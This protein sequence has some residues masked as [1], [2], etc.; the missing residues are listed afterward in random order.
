MNCDEEKPACLNCCSTGRACDGDLPVE[1]GRATPQATTLDERSPGPSVPSIHAVSSSIPGTHEERRCFENFRRRFVV[2]FS[3]YF[4][5][6][7]WDQLT[8]GS[9]IMIQPYATRLLHMAPCTISST[10]SWILSGR[11]SKQQ[12][13][14]KTASSSTIKPLAADGRT[15]EIVRTEM[16]SQLRVVGFSLSPS[17]PSWASTIQLG[18]TWRAG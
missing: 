18:C 13:A 11:R 2:E 6:N 4:D 17:R 3:G 16:S 12:S 9:V 8:H 14:V 10:H 7:F 1:I 5:S 15:L